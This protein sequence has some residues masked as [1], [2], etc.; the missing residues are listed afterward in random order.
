MGKHSDRKERDEKGRDHKDKKRK[1]R[2]D[3]DQDDKRTKRKRHSKL[4]DDSS[5]SASEE[6]Q[7]VENPH[8]AP[9]ETISAI[10][11]V[12]PTAPAETSRDPAAAPGVAREDWMLT[13][14][15]DFDFSGNRGQPIERRKTEAELKKEAEEKARSIIRSERELNPFFQNDGDGHPPSTSTTEL[16][17]PRKKYEY[18][19]AGSSWRMMKLRR[20]LQMAEEEDRP[21]EVVAIERY[22]SLEEFREAQAERAYLDDRK[23]TVKR[24]DEFGRDI[25]YRPSARKS[26]SFHKPGE[27]PS[28]VRSNSS[29][30]TTPMTPRN[31]SP[32]VRAAAGR[33]LPTISTPPVTSPMTPAQPLPTVSTDDLNK[34]YSKVLKAKLMNAADA[35]HLEA[36][37]EKQKAIH[38]TQSQSGGAPASVLLNR[39]NSRGRLQDIG[40]PMDSPS[41]SRQPKI[42]TDRDTHDAKGNRVR[43]SAEDD[44]QELFDLVLQERMAGSDD[45]D[46]QM[47][48]SIA[49]D[50]TYV[51]NLDYV[52]DNVDR[53]SKRRS[54]T[55][56]KKRKIAIEDYQRHEQALRKCRFC[57]KDN[58]KP[59]CPVVALGNFCYLALPE[60]VDMVPGH[61]LIVPLEHELTSL[62]CDD[63]TWTEIRNF[64][65]CLMKMFM[66]EN[67]GV[68]F[69]EQ[70]INFKWRRHTVIE[71]IPVPM[72]HWEDAPALYKEAIL[73]SDDEWTQHQKVIDTSKNGIRRSM[74]KNL[75]YFHVWF[76]PNRG[77][78]HVI[79]NQEQWPE[80]F[81]REVLASVL[82]LPP[83]LWRKP[84]RAVVSANDDRMKTFL[85]KWKPHDWTAM[86]TGGDY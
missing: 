22:G 32:S 53:L 33:L 39:I 75:P 73:A 36:E 66:E 68:I 86:L 23:S 59:A 77:M 4:D 15:D 25:P 1:R 3:K 69:L 29:R 47:A 48:S 72:E 35:A 79:E 28:S 44:Q 13:R 50:A 84:K 20:V 74:V 76:D 43:Y 38:A 61:C 83:H 9:E 58:D 57:F 40:S 45:M 82:D 14:G 26:G 64:Q 60:T 42:K 8:A 11:T 51:N 7:W 85:A 5:A 27:T 78:G 21:V 55:E 24:K 54:T 62:E 67:K 18:G 65:K 49:A 56:D 12:A 17:T 70:V 31:E 34:L 52:D 10:P 16:E 80:W 81:G 6:E 37:Y 2:K 19:D 30:A 71:C 46:K 63:D 41:I